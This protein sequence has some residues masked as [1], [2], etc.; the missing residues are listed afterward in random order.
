MTDEEKLRILRG[1]LSREVGQRE[2]AEQRAA[3]LE[4]LHANRLR[5]QRLTNRTIHMA[6]DLLREYCALM[7]HAEPQPPAGNDLVVDLRA[8]LDDRDRAIALC[9]A[10]DRCEKARDALHHAVTDEYRG[11]GVDA[12]MAAHSVYE[13]ASVEL[14][15]AVQTW[16]QRPRI[17]GEE[18]DR[19][20]L[21]TS[22]APRPSSLRQDS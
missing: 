12:V 20:Q 5:V 22:E 8:V 18:E 6:V 10:A 17:I 16:R 2:A 14:Y 13:R 3:E 1:M 11:K 4:R 7:E 21:T 15:A 19:E 9:E